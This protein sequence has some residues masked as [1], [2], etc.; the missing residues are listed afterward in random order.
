MALVDSTVRV[1]NGPNAVDTLVTGG[2]TGFPQLANTGVPFAF[3]D[4]GSGL[5]ERPAQQRPVLLL[6]HRVRRELVRVG[7]V[8]PGVA[9]H[10]PGGRA[11]CGQASNV[12]RPR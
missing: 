10:R 2:N 12:T 8:E 7:S 9:A 6:G 4:D 5:I 11:R 1:N 3:T